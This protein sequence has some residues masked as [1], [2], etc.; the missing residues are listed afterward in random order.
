MATLY[1]DID[2]VLDGFTL[3][4]VAIDWSTKIIT[5]PTIAMTLIQSVPTIIFELS[6]PEFHIALR[7]LTASEDGIVFPPALDY[8]K[9][10][11]VGGVS[12]APVLILIN[13][14]TVTFENSQYAVNLAFAN[15]NVGDNINVNLVSV[16]SANS[17]GLVQA[18]EITEINAKLG[19]LG[20]VIAVPSTSAGVLQLLGYLVAKTANESNVD[21]NDLQTLRNRA[22]NADIIQ[23]QLVKTLTT[24]KKEADVDVS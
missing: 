7:E 11:N 13:G 15:S 6:L 12:L 23:T 2:Y 14:Y 8:S 20:E 5:I 21:S 19:E 22:N 4:A 18:A 17:A 9:A 16:R 1:V 24:F 10:S 3:D